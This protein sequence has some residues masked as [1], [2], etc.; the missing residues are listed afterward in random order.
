MGDRK[1][2]HTKGK[3][4]RVKAPKGAE[5]FAPCSVDARAELTLPFPRTAR[6]RS[7]G[8]TGKDWEA[9]GRLWTASAYELHDPPG[10]DGNVHRM[11]GHPDAIQGDMTRRIV[12]TSAAADI[13][14]E[15]ADLEAE[16]REWRLLLQIDSDSAAKMMWGASS[17]GS[18]RTPSPPTA[19]TTFASRCCRSCQ[20]GVA[21]SGPASRFQP[22]RSRRSSYEGT[23]ALFARI[24]IAG[25]V[26]VLAA[27]LVAAFARRSGS[28]SFSPRRAS[29]HPCRRLQCQ[30]D[31]HSGRYVH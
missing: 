18:A 24:S 6:A 12:Y 15:H 16:A 8:L 23:Q 28:S 20:S 19:S 1:V 5:V 26:L 10:R 22:S 3:L 2:L 25:A 31:S 14:V 17:S 29:C 13:D 27:T 30:R 9:Y 21:G 11:L 7:T 4:A